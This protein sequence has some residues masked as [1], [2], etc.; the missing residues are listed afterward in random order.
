MSDQANIITE[1]RTLEAMIRIYCHGHHGRRSGLCHEC[2]ELLEYAAMRLEKCPF[3]E[4]KPKC[5]QC[6]A[7]CYKPD[8]RSRIRVVMRY[9]GPRLFFRHPVVWGTH[10]LKTRKE[11]KNE[12]T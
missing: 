3:Q 10:Y 8:M 1:H 6:P 12:E 5:S 11:S 4:H 2:R 7:H 9:A